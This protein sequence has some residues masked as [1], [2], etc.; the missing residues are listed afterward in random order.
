MRGSRPGFGYQS[1]TFCVT[2]DNQYNSQGWPITAALSFKP[3]YKATSTSYSF[4]C[5]SSSAS[6]DCGA[7]FVLLYRSSSITSWGT[8]AALSFKPFS[9]FYCDNFYQTT[10]THYVRRGGNCNDGFYCGFAYVFLGSSFSATVWH[11]GATLSF[12]L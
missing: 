8:G 3:I 2:L 1:G 7:F 11:V 12:K 4:R 5:G 6:F 10:T 9:S